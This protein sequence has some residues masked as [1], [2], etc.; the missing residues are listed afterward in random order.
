MATI[1]FK[2][3]E[4]L[5]GST[6]FNSWKARL[7]TIL[8]ENDLDDIVLNVTEEKTTN[9]GRLAYKRK[10]GKARRIIYDSIRESLMPNITFLKTAK[11]CYD[12]LVN[13]YGKK[14]HS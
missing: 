8:D 7:T 2:L 6:N 12:T 5:Y 4:K 14:A 13:L 1:G 11:E 9:A 10:Q 3:E